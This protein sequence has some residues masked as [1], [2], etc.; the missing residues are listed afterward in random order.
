MKR[1]PKEDKQ[2]LG[3]AWGALFKYCFPFWAPF[4]EGFPKWRARALVEF[5]FPLWGLFAK[6]PYYKGQAVRRDG[7]GPR[8]IL[9]FFWVSWKTT[10]ERGQ[11]S[12]GEG[13]G[14]LQI[15][16]SFWGLFAT[17]T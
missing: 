10:P 16:F 8:Q 7:I 5:C 17:K 4:A 15:S 13:R 2:S 12:L 14:P 1:T 6:D 11:A 9:L 3:R